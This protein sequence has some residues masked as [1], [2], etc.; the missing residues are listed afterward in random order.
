M[1]QNSFHYCNCNVAWIDKYGRG[2]LSHYC[3]CVINEAKC[4]K[5]LCWSFTFLLILGSALVNINALECEREDIEQNLF[6]FHRSYTYI[7]FFGD[8]VC[9]IPKWNAWY[10]FTFPSNIDLFWFW[11]DSLYMCCSSGNFLGIDQD[12]NSKF[13]LTIIPSMFLLLDNAIK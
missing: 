11:F 2:F 12:I 13:S 6:K 4:F 9:V 8:Y 5:G 3:I 7:D 1:E 10:S